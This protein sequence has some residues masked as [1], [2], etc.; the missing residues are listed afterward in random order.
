MSK[1]VYICK[2]K[3][4]SKGRIQLPK[5]FLMANDIELGTYVRLQSM[6]NS[7]ACK[8]EFD[9]GKEESEILS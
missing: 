5:S 3:I 8:L 4:D 9:N 6:Y 1:T 7:S 2:C